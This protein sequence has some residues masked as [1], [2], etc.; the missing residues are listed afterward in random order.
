[1]LLVHL[2]GAEEWSSA[3][4]C[5]VVRPESLGD[6]GFIHL[7]TP[8]QVHLPANRLYRGRGDLMLLYIDPTLLAA[9]VLWEPGAATD[10]DS[11]LFPHLYGPLPVCAVIKVTAYRPDPDGTFPPIGQSDEAQEST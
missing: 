3:R 2:C 11:M 9:P 7:S 1:M 4:A 10:P 8:D 5:G 6:A